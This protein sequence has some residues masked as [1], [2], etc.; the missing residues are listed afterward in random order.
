MLQLHVLV[1][2][3]GQFQLAIKVT[4]AGCYLC[5]IKITDRRRKSRLHGQSSELKQKLSFV[6]CESLAETCDRDT[7][8]TPAKMNLY[9]L[10]I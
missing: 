6:F 10:E 1:F 2:S 5:G 8:A 9:R 3:S 7:S 4:I